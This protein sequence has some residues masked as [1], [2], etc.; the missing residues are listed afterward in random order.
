MTCHSQPGLFYTS[1][2]SEGK[3][4][5]CP[6]FIFNCLSPGEQKE[7]TLIKTP[8][9]VHNPHFQDTLSLTIEPLAK[10]IMQHSL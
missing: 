6:L 1:D 7:V 3:D 4:K 2:N 9:S 10:K 5:S 8:P